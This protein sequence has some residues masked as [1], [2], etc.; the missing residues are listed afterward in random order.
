MSNSRLHKRGRTAHVRYLYI[1]SD[2]EGPAHDPYSRDTQGVTYDNGLT[3]ALVQGSL[4]GWQLV[5]RRRGEKRGAVS[6]VAH[7]DRDTARLVARFERLTGLTLEQHRELYEDRFHF[8]DP[9]GHPS[10][11]L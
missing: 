10:Q 5:V 8:D 9:M 3:V 7:S 6:R 11:Y 1:D 4:T 2:R